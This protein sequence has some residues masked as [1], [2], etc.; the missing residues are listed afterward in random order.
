MSTVRA[1]TVF[2]AMVLGFGAC[3]EWRMGSGS[4]TPYLHG[5][6]PVRAHTERGGLRGPRLGRVV[7]VDTG[8]VLGDIEISA[9]GRVVSWPGSTL[10]HRSAAEAVGAI[11]QARWE[12]TTAAGYSALCGVA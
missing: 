5:D 1:A 4:T 7:E 2:E 6:I 11:A 9:D 3:V 10:E 12:S 8:V